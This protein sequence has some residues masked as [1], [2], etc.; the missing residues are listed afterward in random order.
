MNINLL[1]KKIWLTLTLFILFSGVFAQTSEK[2][3]QIHSSQLIGEW[4]EWPHERSE[5]NTVLKPVK[6]APVP[7]IDRQETPFLKLIL[8]A[9]NTLILTRYCGYCPGLTITETSGTYEII[10]SNNQKTIE[11]TFNNSD[12]KV[13]VEVISC[14]DDKLITNLPAAIKN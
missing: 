11:I 13:I 3:N 10:T 7:G 14:T 4:Y 8:K 6:Y 1:I 12:T 2:S 9:D 5:G